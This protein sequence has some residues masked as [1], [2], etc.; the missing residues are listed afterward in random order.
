[1]KRR[2]FIKISA[3]GTLGT[4]LGI[5]LFGGQK[6]GLRDKWGELLPLNDFGHTGEKV[7]ML[8]VGGF[9]IGRMSDH[10]AQK[11]IETGIAGGIR[12]FDAAESYVRGENEVK[13]GKFL[14]PKYRDDIYLMTKTKARDGKTALNHLEGSLRR[15]KTDT[16]DLWLIH[17][18]NSV[19]DIDRLIEQGMVDAFVE[20]KKSGKARHIGFSGHVAPKANLHMLEKTGDLMQACMLPVNI[21]DPS[22]ESFINDVIPAL[23]KQKSAVIGMKSLSGGSF[24]GGG[25]EG[26]LG[27]SD[28]VID[29]VSVK[30]AIHFAL[31][32][33]VDVLVTGA[34]DADMLQEKIDL[35][36]T[37]QKLT[38]A[39]QDQLVKKVANFAGNRIEYYKM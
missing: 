14:I 11:T 39:E 25:F 4:A 16:V 23:K 27:E 35:V 36:N 9:H 20:A 3:A 30:D 2:V 10:E 31:S 19:E 26:H 32:M 28:M 34:K 37:F 6:S 13:Y 29:H 15:M 12:F 33:P 7:T 8:G 24:W 17:S 38:V 18:V 22:Y 21:L 5:P 1:M